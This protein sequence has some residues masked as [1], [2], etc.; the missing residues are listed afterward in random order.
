MN[1]SR[2]EQPLLHF[3][4]M[5]PAKLIFHYTCFVNLP[6]HVQWDNRHFVIKIFTML[7]KLKHGPTF[8][9]QREV[10]V[11]RSSIVILIYVLHNYEVYTNH[12]MW[13][14]VSTLHNYYQL[15][16]HMTE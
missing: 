7:C 16:G 2:S 8:C 3:I 10:F 13:E 9:P 11:K 6:S 12:C 15:I 1:F 5:I 14:L 4:A